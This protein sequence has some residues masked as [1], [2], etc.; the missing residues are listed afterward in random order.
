MPV[1]ADT[2][3]TATRNRVLVVEDDPAGSDVMR[4]M[5]AR[6]GYE[7]D[8]ASDVAL[9][10]A[11]LRDHPRFVILDLHLPD[12]SGTAVLRRVRE[13]H[14]DIKVAV[15]TGTSE[16]LLLADALMLRPD[17]H[18]TKPVD[19]A[20]VLAWLGS[21][22]GQAAAHLPAASGDGAASMGA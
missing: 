16:G 15:T 18:F 21:A 4:R 1:P 19:F 7:I 3:T 6:H 12:G 14:P 5:L 11:K 10:L 17:A 8:T 9:A 22:N 2:M 13:A 20:Q